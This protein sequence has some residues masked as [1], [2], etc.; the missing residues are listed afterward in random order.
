MC[1]SH[2]KR[3]CSRGICKLM[4]VRCEYYGFTILWRRERR[5]K[6]AQAERRRDAVST[7][8]LLARNRERPSREANSVSAD[9]LRNSNVRHRV[10]DSPTP[11]PIL[12]QV[13]PVHTIMSYLFKINLYCVI[14]PVREPNN[15]GVSH[16]NAF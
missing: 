10:H 13:N 4:L 16:S 5:V 11:A 14:Q 2:A 1:L 8:G 15:V 12:S 6:K 7:L 3:N 9:H